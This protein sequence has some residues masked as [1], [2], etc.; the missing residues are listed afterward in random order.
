MSNTSNYDTTGLKVLSQETGA[1][2]IDLTSLTLPLSVLAVVNEDVARRLVVLPL[3]VDKNHLFVAAADPNDRRIVDDIAFM[4]GKKVVAYVA[5]A[6]LLDQAISEAYEARRRGQLYWRGKRAREDKAGN[7]AGNPASNETSETGPD[8]AQN[9]IDPLLKQADLS[10]TPPAVRKPFSSDIAYRAS[11]PATVSSPARARV[12]VVDDEP[13]IRRIL[14]QAL[15]QRGYEV[16]EAENGM[17]ALRLIK[18]REPNA[19]LL[20]AMLPD[21][22]GFDICKRLKESRRYRHIPI[23]MMTAVYKGWRMAADLKE[24]Y[25]VAGYIEKPFDI[26]EVVRQVES[27]LTGQPPVTAA[28]I[29]ALSAEAQRLY[30]EGARAF[31]RGDLDGAIAAITS[32][33]AIDP[34]NPTLRNQLGLLYA[35]RG[36]DFAAVQELE[37]AVELEPT[38]FST[39]RNLAILFQWH[40]FRRKA[41]EIWERA[42]AQ[43]PD[44]ETRSEI[45]GILVQLL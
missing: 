41:C 23:V 18:E 10:V 29:N 20:D 31:Q 45:K 38:R 30:A 43:A 21:V 25:G 36:Q 44:E 35:Q 14:H 1:P 24:A 8:L 26:Q 32:A 9:P 22:H 40:G 16:L 27:A 33:V 28:D 34:L 37:M 6:E 17:E 13:V 11:V 4:S 19:I 42:L 3:R 5:P 15:A 12:L 39:L 7:A 2:A